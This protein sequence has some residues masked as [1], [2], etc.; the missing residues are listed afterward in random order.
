M[1]SE[2]RQYRM[3]HDQV[4]VRYLMQT[5]PWG[6]WRINPRLGEVKRGFIERFGPRRKGLLLG[7]L[8]ARPDAI[9]WGLGPVDIIECLV[10]PEWW[11]I[12]KLNEYEELFL[13]TEEFAHLW[14]RPIRKILLI[15]ISNPY[16]EARAAARGIIV[17]PHRPREV[18]HYLGTIEARKQIP[19]LS[20][21]EPPGG[22]P[23]ERA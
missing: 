8:G 13:M 16:M 23:S 7:M 20:G 21:I 9:A 2:R 10:R 17:I 4:L 5:Y 22:G 6:T 11:K 19:L 14:D 3:I 1:S 15:T 12:E 18:E